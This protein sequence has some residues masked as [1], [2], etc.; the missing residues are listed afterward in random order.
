MAP[1]AATPCHDDGMS[2]YVH[3]RT[4]LAD[5]LRE[6]GPTAPTLC[7]GWEARHVAAHVLLRERSPRVGLGLAIPALTPQSDRLTAELADT[8]RDAAGF[9]ALVDQV[10]RPA[11]RWT[12]VAWAG[13]AANL[14]EFYVHTE[15]VR[16]GAGPVPARD[17]EPEL[18]R[19]LWERLGSMARL[20]YRRSPAGV[21]LV[22]TDGPRKAVHRPHGDHGTVVVRGTVGELTLHA[23][24]RGAAATVEIVGAPEDVA[25][26]Q[27]VLPGG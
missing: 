25:A 16:R 9:A 10:A 2:W 22:V 23:L 4:A 12:P 27:A 6:A 5:A 13:D 17:L 11:S 21:V 26:L 20:G 3:E 8:A 24:G 14:V 7:A 18:A 19:A 15:D 1:R